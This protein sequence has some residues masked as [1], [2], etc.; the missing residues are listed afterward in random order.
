MALYA[1]RNLGRVFSDEDMSAG[2]RLIA[3]FTSLSMILPLVGNATKDLTAALKAQNIASTVAAVLAK[4]K[5]LSDIDN[6]VLRTVVAN[7]IKKQTAATNG[8]TAALG[9]EAIAQTVVNSSLLAF[10]G[11][12]TLAVVAVAA[13]GTVIYALVKA[14]NADADAAKEA[15]AGVEVLS[16]AYNDAKNAATE[17]KNTIND[18]DSAV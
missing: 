7:I 3:I 12:A 16:K 10:L 17:L 2:D 15:A 9:A 4:E 1:V 8:Q 18:W 11:Y 13:I 14:Y 5:K 6:I